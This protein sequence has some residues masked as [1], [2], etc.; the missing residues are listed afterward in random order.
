MK[1]VTL[2]EKCTCKTVHFT[3]DFLLGLTFDFAGVRHELREFIS[4]ALPLKTAFLSIQKQISHLVVS[5]TKTTSHI[6]V[7]HSKNRVL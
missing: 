7:I 4:G 5:D 2:T 1:N 6:L 3:L